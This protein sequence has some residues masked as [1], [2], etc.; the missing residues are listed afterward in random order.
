MFSWLRRIDDA[1]LSPPH[2]FETVLAFVV[3]RM[4]ASFED[5]SGKNA[6]QDAPSGQTPSSADHP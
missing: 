5:E 4:E 1:V 6:K 2:R 3:S